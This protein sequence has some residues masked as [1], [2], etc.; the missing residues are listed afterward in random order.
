MANHITVQAVQKVHAQGSALIQ[1][2]II[3]QYGIVVAGPRPDV[4]LNPVEADALQD[5]LR[6]GRAVTKA[7]LPSRRERGGA[8]ATG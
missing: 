2:H 5:G 3:H 6:D 8:A 4:L 1:R 7:P